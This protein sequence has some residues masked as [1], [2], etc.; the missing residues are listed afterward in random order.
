MSKKFAPGFVEKFA[1]SHLWCATEM[2]ES[3][4]YMLFHNAVH[5]LV[6]VLAGKEYIEDFFRIEDK[7]PVF[8][9]ERIF[10]TMLDAYR[11]AKTHWTLKAPNY[12]AYFPLL[13]EEYQDARV[14]ITH[15]NP[16]ITYPSF[17]RLL[18]SFNIAFDQNRAFDKHRFAQILRLANR[19]VTVPF[20]YRK[21]HP[22]KEEQI[23]DCMYEELFSDPIAMVK[24]IYQQFD[25]EYT[26][27]FEEKMKVYLKNNKQGKYGLHKYSLAEY[28]LDGENLY[29]DHKDYMDY[30]GFE[31]PDNMERPDSF[32]FGL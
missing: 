4:L 1:E 31:I 5:P 3:L 20:N 28:G 21:E 25:I 6:L 32:N 26:D 15:R 9:Y 22:E 19:F 13:F 23:F 27:E 30:Y 8:R 16:I 10:F 18:E 7:R 12:S 17:C 11:P 14:V 24:K 29:Q 2:E